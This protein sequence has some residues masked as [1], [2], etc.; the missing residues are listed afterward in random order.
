MISENHFDAGHGGQISTKSTTRNSTSGRKQKKSKTKMKVNKSTNFNGLPEKQHAGK[1]GSKEHKKSS[2]GKKKKKKKTDSTKVSDDVVLCRS[3]GDISLMLSDVSLFEPTVQTS[4]TESGRRMDQFG[5]SDDRLPRSRR[6]EDSGSKINL[7]VP[8]YRQQQKMT[9][10]TGSND[11]CLAL[12]SSRSIMKTSTDDHSQFKES[13]TDRLN[14]HVRSTVKHLLHFRV[15]KIAQVVCAIYICI[16]T[17]KGG[18]RDS[19][20]GVVIDM[21]SDERTERGV[22]LVNGTGMFYCI[23]SPRNTTATISFLAYHSHLQSLSSFSW[24]ILSD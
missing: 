1:C 23:I 24:P 9:I 19:E 18:L 4:S 13:W 14:Y 22:L 20:T 21:D 2:S 7:P 5:L 16:M 12:G 11:E 17:L 6:D 15:L 8:M 10:P 3:D